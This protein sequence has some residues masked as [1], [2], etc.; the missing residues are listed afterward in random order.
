MTRVIRYV[1]KEYE[2]PKEGVE[3]A[4]LVEIKDLDPALNPR[5]EEKQRVRFVWELQNQVNSNN[6]A[7][8]VFQTFNLSI[9]PMSFLAKTIYDLTGSDAGE[10]FDLDSL[11]GTVA[12]L[13]LKHSEGNDGRVY[14]NIVAIMRL[15]NAEEAAKEK[16]EERRV[17]AATERV[18]TEARKP[19]VVT[20][21]ASASDAGEI[22]DEDEDI[23]F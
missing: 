5:G 13:V 6:Y 3:R 7:F 9:H 18:M 12:D 15:R 11:Q 4:R 10:S 8:K 23:P 20:A 17:K 21:P 16:A 22:T 19:R 2:L 1:P 14:C